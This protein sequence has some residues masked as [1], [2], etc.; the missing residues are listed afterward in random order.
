ML[1][2]HLEECL[3]F[4]EMPFVTLAP[5]GKF[6]LS[7]EARKHVTVVLTGEGAD[8]VFLGYRSFF[9]NAI[10]DT[11]EADRTSRSASTRRRRLKLPG[12]AGAAVDKLS[13]LIFRKDHRRRLQL[14]REKGIRPPN[15][16]KPLINAV[17]EA[18]V[19]AMPLDILCYLGDR[20]EMAHSLEAR[21]P[22]LD[23]ELY[24]AAKWIPVDFKM[25]DGIEKAVLRDAAK[26][27]LPDDLRLRTKK[28]FMLT[29]EA[30]DIFGSDRHLSRKL[31][32]YLSK[33]AFDRAQVFSYGAF[34]AARLIARTPAWK[35]FPVLK[36]LRR[37]ANKVLIYMMQTHMLHRMFVEDPPW[38][39][40]SD[41]PP[42]EQ[43]T[44][45]LD[46]AA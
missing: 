27:I 34:L 23:H 25:R 7:A 39:R 18:R 13:L 35:R 9:A 45:T 29:S 21:L 24:D 12:L 2:D 15:P 19:A 46:L 20:E 17:Q 11:R 37:D 5:V 14:A 8:E 31:R 10:R 32:P 38:R 6:L 16:A 42:S 3:W 28:G 41:R 1:W 40:A 30:I 44:A 43:Q 22:F 33:Q 26:G 36:R 4:S